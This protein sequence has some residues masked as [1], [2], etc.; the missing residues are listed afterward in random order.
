RQEREAQPSTLSQQRNK[1]I[2]KRVEQFPS[3]SDFYDTYDE[4][5]VTERD[6]EEFQKYLATLTDAEKALLNV[7]ANFYVVE[8]K[9]IGGLVMP[10]ILLVE[11]ADGTSEELRIPAEIWRSNNYDVTKL[12]V[13]SK[14]IKTITLDPH[15]ETADVD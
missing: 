10:V 9:N 8:L 3:L 1:P 4:F 2:P 7:G 5:R 6:K 13:T 14:E 15:L 11:Y 12:I